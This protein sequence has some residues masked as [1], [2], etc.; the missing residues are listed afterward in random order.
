MT[1]RENTTV[2]TGDLAADPVLRHTNSNVPVC[3]FTITSDHTKPTG[4]VETTWLRC[5]AWDDLAEHLV[6]SASKGD[7]LI[8]V[9][10]LRASKWWN[11]DGEERS[12]LEVSVEEVGMSLKNVDLE[13][14]ISD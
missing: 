5:T 6:N 14:F 11:P 12:G 9:G 2:F 3:N 1:L 8:I 4:E 7:R 13:P 10:R